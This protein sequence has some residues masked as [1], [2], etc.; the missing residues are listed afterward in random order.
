MSNRRRRQPGALIR[1]RILDRCHECGRLHDINA[2]PAVE[3][4]PGTTAYLL[5]CP[6]CRGDDDEAG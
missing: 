1:P 4:E 3:L 2:Y 5:V 6:Q